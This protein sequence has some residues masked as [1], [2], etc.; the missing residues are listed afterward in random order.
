MKM[1]TPGFLSEVQ[2]PPKKVDYIKLLYGKKKLPQHNVTSRKPS[3]V[4]VLL[5]TPHGD[6]AKVVEKQLRRKAW[7]AMP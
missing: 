3:I 4:G 5:Q 2:M 1:N 6:V 7:T